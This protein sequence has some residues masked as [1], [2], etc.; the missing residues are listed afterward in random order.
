ML[1]TCTAESRQAV[2]RRVVPSRLGQTADRS[3]HG[4]VGDLDE[5]VCNLIQAHGLV[6]ASSDVFIDLFGQFFEKRFARLLIKTLIL[7][8]TEDLGEEVGE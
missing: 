5:A 3:C 8:F 7:V 1:T 4:L 6:L 2:F